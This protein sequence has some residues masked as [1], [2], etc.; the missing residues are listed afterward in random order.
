MEALGP[1]IYWTT[2]PEGAAHG[3]RACLVHNPK[4]GPLT[5]KADW[6]RFVA[7]LRADGWELAVVPTRKAGDGEAIARMAI[8]DGAETILV[9]GGDGSI[10]EVL[11]VLVGTDVSLGILPVGT[12][13][14]LARELGIGTDL[15][16]ALEI[17]RG[18]HARRIDVGRL[19][20][21]GEPDRFFCAMTGIGFDAVS[22]MG[23]DLGLLKE[24]LGRGAFALT[25]M[26]TSLHHRPSRLTLEVDGKRQRQLV[27]MMIVAN[28]AFYGVDFLKVTPEASI[29]DG[30]L[31]VAILRSRSFLEAW[32][33]FFGIAIGRVRNLPTYETLRCK[34]LTVRSGKPV[35]FQVDGDLVGTT[36]VTLEV[37]PSGLKVF[38]PEN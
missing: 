36:P 15:S 29:S 21:P 20:R 30:E 25:A 22:M 19:M 1:R 13:N 18:G 3:R 35:P 14:V 38:A 8:A 32:R 4:A 34:R 5:G 31:D 26:R 11:P 27:Y 33:D 10:N 16:R 9:A 12:A 7:P 2:R 17:L 6:D 23:E 24:R 28:T 37:V